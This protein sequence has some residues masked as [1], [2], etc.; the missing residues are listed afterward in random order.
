V[1]ASE[2]YD[3]ADYIRDYDEFLAIVREA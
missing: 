1:F 3:A 2:R